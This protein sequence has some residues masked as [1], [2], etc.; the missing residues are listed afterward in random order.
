MRIGQLL[1]GD[2]PAAFS[3]DLSL[4]ESIRRL[5]SV[6]EKDGFL[7]GLRTHEGQRVFGNV[8]R[9]RVRLTWM[10]PFMGNVF[11]PRFIGRFEAVGDKTVLVGKFGVVPV[12]RAWACVIAM[13]GML[14]AGIVVSQANPGLYPR[15][16]LMLVAV[17]V[18][19][20]G[21]VAVRLSQWLTGSVR[22][23]LASFITASLTGNDGKA[24]PTFPDAA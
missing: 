10:T 3:S 11:R 14:G 1:F 4:D 19:M 17:G 12:V 15:P 20:G 6:V 8:A 23:K 18:S 9:Q 13:V 22:R 16:V 24:S 2:S 21:F 5:S 7:S